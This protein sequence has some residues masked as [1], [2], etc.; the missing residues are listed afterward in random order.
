M[1]IGAVIIHSSKYT[2]RRKYVDSLISFFE[3]SGVEVNII[4]GVFT[5][6]EYYDARTNKHNQKIAK[7]SVGA[8]LAHMNAYKLAIE[9]GYDAVY[10]FEDDV[11]I[12]VPNYEVMHK[13]IKN[14]R[15]SYDILFL[16]NLE[17]YEGTGH[18]GRIHYKNQYGDIYKCS[19]LSGTQAYYMP[20]STIRLMYETQA[21]EVERGRIYLS[22]ALQIHCQKQSDLFLRIITPVDTERFFKDVGANDSIINNVS[23]AAT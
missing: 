1:K 21:R 12:N 20:R 4:E 13:W 7:G 17:I 15:M 10:I 8:A 14:I 6:D 3:G 2:Q 18:D 16:T 11:Q 22:D 9:K 5:D 23:R 19:C